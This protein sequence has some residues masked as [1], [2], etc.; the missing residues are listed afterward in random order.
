MI[1]RFAPFNN[2]EHRGMI[3]LI[4]VIENNIGKFQAYYGDKFIVVDNSEGA[5]YNTNVMNAYRK[6]SKWIKTPAKTP[7]SKKWIAMQKTK[8][9]ITK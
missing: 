3:T 8:R 5:D 6:M 2:K 1:K 7:I 9:G 4:L